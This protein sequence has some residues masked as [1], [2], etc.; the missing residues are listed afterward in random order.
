M[1]TREFIVCQHTYATDVNK[2][3]NHFRCS[4]NAISF[5]EQI[6]YNT[7]IELQGDS[8]FLISINIADIDSMSYGMFVLKSL[9]NTSLFTV[10][11][12]TRKAGRL[13]G[14]EYC[15][16]KLYDLFVVENEEP[17]DDYNEESIDNEER[18]LIERC[19]N[20]YDVY[21]DRLNAELHAIWRTEGHDDSTKV[22]AA[23]KKRQVNIE[24]SV[25]L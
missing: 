17:I 5:I 13:W 4:Q 19:R 3:I 23:L 22:L 21:L 16:T 7:Q 9:C 1:T 8:P 12:R 11:R 25:V 2:C 18:E 14:Y 15:D 24:E 6:L 20:V 10:M